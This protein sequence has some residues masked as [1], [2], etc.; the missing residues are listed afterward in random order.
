MRNWILLACFTSALVA[1][2]SPPAHARGAGLI[3]DL[4]TLGQN[5]FN[6][7]IPLPYVLAFGGLIVAIVVLG[8]LEARK[9]ARRAAQDGSES[10]SIRLDK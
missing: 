1:L 7:T 8:V 3:G 2:D 10:S 6:G 5:V 9:N 4:W